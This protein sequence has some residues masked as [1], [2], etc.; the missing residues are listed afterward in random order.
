MWA[1]SGVLSTVDSILRMIGVLGS[2]CYPR[3]KYSIRFCNSDG[4]L[5]TLE[6]YAIFDTVLDT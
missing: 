6:V 1:V 5:V 2:V 3:C 4:G